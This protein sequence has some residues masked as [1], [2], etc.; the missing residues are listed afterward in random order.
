MLL[1]I[2]SVCLLHFLL[3]LGV[4][5]I[6][7]LYETTA[8]HDKN[9]IQFLSNKIKQKIRRTIELVVKLEESRVLYNK[10]LLRPSQK[11]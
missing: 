8:K 5:K 2:A 6:A 3:C 7:G 11:P 9:K 10:F 1:L 4:Q